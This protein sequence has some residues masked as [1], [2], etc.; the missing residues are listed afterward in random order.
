MLKFMRATILLLAAAAV[1]GAKPVPS[2]TRYWFGPRTV[3]AGYSTWYYFRVDW[4]VPV[5]CDPTTSRCDSGDYPFKGGEAVFFYTTG[6][7]PQGIWTLYASVWATYAVCDVQGTTFTLHRNNCAGRVETFTTPGTG[8]HYVA[9][10]ESLKSYQKNVYVSSLSGLPA[11]TQP[12]WWRYS[13]G[14][15]AGPVRTAGSVPYS[16]NGTDALCL[17]MKVPD[18]ATAG[19]YTISITVSDAPSGGNSTV[20]QFPITVVHLPPTQTQAIDWTSVPPIPG[21]SQWEQQMVSTNKGGAQWCPDKANPTEVMYFGVEAQVWYYD[22]AR[23]YYQIADYTGDQQWANCALNIASQYSDYILHAKGGIPGWRVF[24]KG[25]VM[26][27]CPT[28][29]PKYAEALHALIN[30]NISAQL[31]GLPWD[32]R[33]REM[34][35][36]LDLEVAQQNAFG[37]PHKNLTNTADILIGCLLAYTDGTGRYAMY[38]TFLTG[39]V[40]EALIGYWDLTHDARVPYAIRRMIDDIWARYDT[41]KHAI[42]Y[43]AD[44][45]PAKCGNVASWFNTATGGNCGLNDHAGLNNMVA[46]AF[47]WYWR[48]T[49][50]NTYLTRGDDIFSHSLDEDLYSGKQFSQNYRWSFDY[51]KWR[52]NR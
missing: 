18:T 27:L 33:G 6:T 8:T 41:K 31:S 28:C 22:G 14:C 48:Q 17:Q 32:G 1:L 37:E 44:N 24:P 36:G 7:P 45:D 34:A 20:L 5:T 21:L 3:I 42:M 19:D 50:D 12:T 2:I 40:M 11:N 46:P 26:S 4:Q 38:Q 29:D 52:S 23:V 43:N 25:L 10:V 51:V 39:L 13:Y 9:F 49:G 15:T 35:Y 16:W 47:A 30:A